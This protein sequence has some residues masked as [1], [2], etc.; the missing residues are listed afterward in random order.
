MGAFCALVP[1]FTFGLLF[2]RSGIYE[3]RAARNF[4]TYA[5]ILLSGP[6][7][8]IHRL[9]GKVGGDFNAV[10]KCVSFMVQR[11]F[12]INAYIDGQQG[13]LVFFHEEE[14]QKAKEAL[15]QATVQVSPKPEPV[16]VTCQGCGAHGRIIPGEESVC[17]YCGSYLS[18]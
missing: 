5:P 15:A 3:R 12:F 13:R 4:D 16:V 1:A 17:E 11:N 8:S 9:A 7:H 2:L 6:E 10:N 18:K 14:E